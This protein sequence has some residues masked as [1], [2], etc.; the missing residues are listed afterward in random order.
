[1]NR[2]ILL[3]IGL[4]AIAPAACAENAAT[5]ICLKAV[6]LPI[7]SPGPNTEATHLAD[8]SSRKDKI[9]LRMNVSCKSGETLIPSSPMEAKDWLDLALPYDFKAEL[10]AAKDYFS[11]D[12]DSTYGYS[13]EYDLYNY[14]NAQWKLKP[15]SEVCKAFP[16]KPTDKK[17]LNWCFYQMLDKIR[18]DYRSPK[19]SSSEAQASDKK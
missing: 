12:V 14:F 19:S 5:T 8:N 1:M 4:I 7:T 11:A 16:P 13:V 6:E 3:A 2:W 10:V 15:D 18:S 17:D 9:V